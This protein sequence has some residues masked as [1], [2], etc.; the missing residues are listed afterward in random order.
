ML[1]HARKASALADAGRIWTISA[2]NTTVACRKT[3]RSSGKFTKCILGIPFG[4]NSPIVRSLS[5][6]AYDWLDVPFTKFGAEVEARRRA[7]GV[8]PPNEIHIPSP[9]ESQESFQNYTE[10]VAQRQKLGLLKPGEVVEKRWTRIPAR[11]QVSGQVAG[12]DDQRP[13]VQGHF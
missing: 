3:R 6:T 10:D 13:A 11:V 12:D 1:P 9:E 7:E 4:E 5:S 2:R 8:Y